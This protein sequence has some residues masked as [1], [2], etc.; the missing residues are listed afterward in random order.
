M[1]KKIILTLLIIVLVISC[2]LILVSRLTDKPE[3]VKPVDPKPVDPVVEMKEIDTAVYFTD[4][5]ADKL[6]KQDVKISVEKDEDK[7]LAV[8][9]KLIEGP[10]G[11]DLYPAISSFTKVNGVIFKDGLCTVDFTE[12]LLLYNEGG[13]LRETMCLYSVVN[14]LCEFGEVKSVSFTVDGKKIETFGHLDLSEPYTKNQ[15]LVK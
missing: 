12:S 1:F 13:T 11:P 9:E 3:P 15:K 4:A 5:A 6:I 7:Y 2:G 8:I 14:T 10:T